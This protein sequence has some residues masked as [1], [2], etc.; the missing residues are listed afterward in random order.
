MQD[1]LKTWIDFYFQVVDRVRRM[2]R[3]SVHAIFQQAYNSISLKF[4][5]LRLLSIV[6]ELT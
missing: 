4:S 1:D 6:L 5:K 2:N 3:N